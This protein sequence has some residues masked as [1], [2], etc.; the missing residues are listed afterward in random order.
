[1]EAVKSSEAERTGRTKRPVR[2][3][4]KPVALEIG[5]IVGTAFLGGVFAAIGGRAATAAMNRTGSGNVVPLRA[6]GNH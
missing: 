3:E 2:R 4:W 6:A 5:K 1:M